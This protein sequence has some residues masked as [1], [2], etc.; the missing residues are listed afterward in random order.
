MLGKPLIMVRNGS[1]YKNIEENQT[2]EVI[3]AAE[4]K[5]SEEISSAL[6]SLL[7]R[8]DEWPEMGLKSRK[9]YE[10]KYPWSKSAKTLLDGY[11]SL[12]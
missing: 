4:G 3:A 2:G 9:L 11:R 12:A 10:E 7:N 5:V 1:I 6:D 8:K